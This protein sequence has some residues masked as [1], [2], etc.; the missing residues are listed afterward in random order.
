MEI[1]ENFNLKNFNTFHVSAHAK[2]FAD[3]TEIGHL[4][5]A[6]NFC[7]EKSIP[8]MLIGQGSNLLFKEDYP[9]LIIELNIKGTEVVNESDTHV[10]AK[11]MCGENWH[12]FVQHCLKEHYY[13]L[14]NLSLIPGTVGAAPVQN[15]GA[16][17]VE[18]ADFLFE[19]EALEIASGKLVTFTNQQCEF[20]YRDSV[21]KKGLKDQYI[22]CSVTFALLKKAQPN[23]SY[24]GLAEALKDLPEEQITPALVS[25]T[26]CSIRRSKLPDPGNLGNAGSFFWN[27]IIDKTQF[28]A[29]QEK[30]PEIIAYPNGDKIKLAAAWLIEKAGWKGYR[31]G[32]VGV[33]KE[34]ALVLVNYGSATG[35]ELYELSV[36]IQASVKALFGIELWP[37]VRII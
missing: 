27:P 2:Y 28:M 8:F 10:Y 13:G 21:F 26:V 36:K 35:A 34:H 17:A 14:E 3:I 11:A 18:I 20:D 31:E 16:Y 22:I 7:K 4:Q 30:F 32:D 25:E 33:H 6:L 1:L 9:G 12:D 24:A 29:L 5:Q 23:L 37:E 15:I 19:L